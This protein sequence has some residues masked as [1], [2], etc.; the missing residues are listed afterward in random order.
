MESNNKNFFIGR[1]VEMS[2]KKE[3]MMSAINLELAVIY[4]N[5][6]MVKIPVRGNNCINESDK[7]WL[8]K[9]PLVQRPR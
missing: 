9:S 7:A 3:G 2:F 4:K 1:W 6:S 5:G 8:L